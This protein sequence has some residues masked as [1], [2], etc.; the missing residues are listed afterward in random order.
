[1][2]DREDKI[3]MFNLSLNNIDNVGAQIKGRYDFHPFS[4][5]FSVVI[6]VK[7]I[8]L[9]WGLALVTLVK[10]KVLF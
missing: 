1:M 9:G 10:H 3:L 4:K 2:C 5:F 6:L 7:L 8:S